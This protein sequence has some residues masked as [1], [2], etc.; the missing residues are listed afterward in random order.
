MIPPKRL[1]LPSVVCLTLLSAP[2]A[3]SQTQ[4]TGR[5]AGTVRDQN[6]ALIVGAEVK[7]VSGATGERR[8]VK[9]DETGAYSMSFLSPGRY[10]V[11]ASATNFAT[12][13]LRALVVITETT[14]LDI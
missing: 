5:I 3:P 10:Q 2:L 7:T 4:T 9:T 1:L 13:S 12:I 11:N 8:S 14:S 6:G